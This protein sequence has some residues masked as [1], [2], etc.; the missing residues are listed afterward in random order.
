M[1]G[2]VGRFTTRDEH[3]IAALREQIFEPLPRQI[4]YGQAEEDCELLA[5]C[6]VGSIG[7]SDLRD[8]R[9]TAIPRGGFIV[10]GMLAYRLGLRRSQLEAPHP[11]D[12]PTVVVDDCSITGLR[13][14]QWLRQSP[15]HRVIFAHLYSHPDLRAAVVAREDRVQACIGARDLTDHAPER[16]GADYDAWREA[17]LERSEGR[18]WAGQIGRIAFA[19]SEP[20]QAFWNPVTKRME[21]SWSLVPPRLHSRNR[22]GVGIPA[23]PVQVQQEPRGAFHPAP[24]ILWGEIDGEVVVGDVDSELSFTLG[25][26]AADMWRAVLQRST[27]DAALAALLEDYDVDAATLSADLQ[28]FIREMRSRG[29]WEERSDALRLVG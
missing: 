29:V 26:V 24:N 14:G 4:S 6:L 2:V 9:F 11:P 22:K 15:S 3:R 16:L 28:H 10:L 23:I 25:G 5:E 1:L 19:W 27:A 20:E 17:R 21:R 7:L 13:F 12:V 18:Y 8:F